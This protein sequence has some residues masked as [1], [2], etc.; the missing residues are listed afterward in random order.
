MITVKN[1]GLL[2]TLALFCLMANSA[3][4][5]V[6]EYSGT[7]T[8]APFFEVPEQGA[9]YR[10]DAFEFS[11]PTSGNY[12]FSS[13]AAYDNYTL[14]YSDPFNPSNS[15]ENLLIVNDDLNGPGSSGFDLHLE[16]GQKYVFVNTSFYSSEAGDFQTTIIGPEAVQPVLA[17]VPEPET[18]ALLLAGIGMVGMVARRKHGRSSRGRPGWGT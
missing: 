12:N 17:A 8:G 4:A 3:G 1:G 6:Y 2:A 11:A 7:T 5:A 10:Y 14:L 16:G 13:V 18:Y 15:D 9:G